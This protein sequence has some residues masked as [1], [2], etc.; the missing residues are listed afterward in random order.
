MR[1]TIF[2]LASLVVAGF[3]LAGCGEQ[4]APEFAKDAAMSD[5]YEIEAGRIAAE[6]GQ[7]DAV[8][9]Y[10]QKMVDAHSKTS[11]ELKQIV[12][13]EKIDVKLPTDLDA[14]HRDMIEELNDADPSEFDEEY[15][16]QQVDAHQ[17][18]ADIFEEYSEDGDKGA[19]KDFA[20]K[21]LPVIQ[22]HLEEAKQLEEQASKAEETK[23]AGGTSDQ[24]GE[25]PPSTDSMQ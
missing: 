20:A 8:R 10:G 22:G 25:T 12:Q 17:A 3:A 14:A 16:E 6:K 18:A 19:L 1:N 21:T 15:A 2:G 23:G 11:D 9:S 13:A 5:L 4:A 7:S 24:G